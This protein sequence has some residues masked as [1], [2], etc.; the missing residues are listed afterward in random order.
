MDLWGQLTP[1]PQCQTHPWALSLSFSFP[2]SQTL[3]MWSSLYTASQNVP[4]AKHVTRPPAS[5]P[6]GDPHPPVWTTSPISPVSLWKVWSLQGLAELPYREWGVVLCQ[7]ADLPSQRGPRWLDPDRLQKDFSLPELLEECASLSWAC[8][9]SLFP[10][11]AMRW[12]EPSRISWAK[13]LS[14]FS[15]LGMCWYNNNHHHKILTLSQ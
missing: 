3:V 9:V 12:V 13:C 7:K 5:N 15:V 8:H 11:C 2:G 6:Q 1:L 14:V 10:R 4:T